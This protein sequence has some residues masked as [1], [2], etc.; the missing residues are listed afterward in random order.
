M[1]VHYRSDDHRLWSKHVAALHTLYHYIVVVVYWW[2]IIYCTVV[3]AQRDGFCQKKNTRF[4][5]WIFSWL[6]WTLSHKFK[7]LSKSAQQKINLTDS[8]YICERLISQD[9]CGEG[10]T[11]QK[12][13]R[14]WKIRVCRHITTSNI[15]PYINILVTNKQ[16]QFSHWRISWRVIKVHTQVGEKGHMNLKSSLYVLGLLYS[17]FI[18]KETKVRT[19]R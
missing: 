17:G 11:I 5:D 2:Y 7:I 18:I 4:D 6:L 19:S 9:E 8:T 3:I 15:S 1:C 10:P 16:C 13:T 12:L 14:W